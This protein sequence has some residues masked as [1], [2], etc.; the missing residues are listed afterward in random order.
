MKYISSLGRLVLVGGFI[1]ATLGAVGCGSKSDPKVQ[2][3]K[4]VNAQI[5]SFSMSSEKDAELSKV[6]FSIENLA[7]TGKIENKKPLAYGK[8]M[9]KIKLSV[10]TASTGT[11]IYVALGNGA[12]EEWKAEKVYDFPEELHELKVKVSIGDD[13][14]KMEYAYNVK[15]N[16]YKFDP[17]TIVWADPVTTVGDRPRLEQDA[18]AYAMKRVDDVWVVEATAGENRYYTYQDGV[19][20]RDMGY[21]GLPTGATIRHIEEYDR[22]PYALASNGYVYRLLGKVWQRIE[23]IGSVEGLLGVLPPRLSAE[24]PDLTL[25]VKGDDGELRFAVYSQGR[26]KV[27]SLAV[28]K[29]FPRDNYRAFSGVKKY[30][31]GYLYL[32]A[33]EDQAIISRVQRSVWYTTNGLDWS[34]IYTNSDAGTVHSASIFKT[35][36]LIYIFEASPSVGLRIW[37]SDNMGRTWRENG[38][39]AKPRDFASFANRRV[40]A[41]EHAVNH[42]IALL[43]S[44][45]TPVGSPASLWI[46]VPKK[47][48]Y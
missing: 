3:V 8:K 4:F 12:Y 6:F 24:E 43:G 20:T 25:L 45:D 40:L 46:G 5:R 29:D 44:V 31:G 36:D 7:D 41:W 1:W 33:L 13:R 48:E 17:E 32:V 47:D 28:P 15:L 39:I 2:E 27:S 21:S 23:A 11:K 34:R 22:K 35:D 18:Y 26:V 10:G 16:K 37:T 38:S 42:N 14:D 30:I 19:F 9:E